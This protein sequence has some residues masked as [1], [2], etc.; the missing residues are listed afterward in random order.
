MAPQETHSLYASPKHGI[1]AP[2]LCS[3]ILNQ[4]NH[5]RCVVKLCRNEYSSLARYIG[6]V[7]HTY[8]IENSINGKL[9]VG[10]TNNILNRW[11]NHQLIANGGKGKYPKHF[12]YLHAAIAKHGSNNFYISILEEN[13]LEHEAFASEQKHIANLRKDGYHLYNLTEGGE[14]T[15]G[16]KASKATKDRISL[17]QTGRKLSNATKQKMSEAKK[18]YFQ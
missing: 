15:S 2:Y 13:I 10:K 11:K 8:L 16:H 9:Y 18:K 6:Y 14:G 4:Y 3:F 5:C 17:A 12:Q 7:W 1:S